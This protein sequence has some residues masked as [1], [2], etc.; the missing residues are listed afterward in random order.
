MYVQADY[1]KHAVGKKILETA[2]KHGKEKMQCLIINLS[3]ETTNIAAKKLYE[4]Y[5]FKAWGTE[6]K[7]M[8]VDQ[9]F[10]DL[11]HMSLLL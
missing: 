11:F 8:R 4:A 2:I 5:G 3:V 1:R 6:A 9:K 7:A 10:H